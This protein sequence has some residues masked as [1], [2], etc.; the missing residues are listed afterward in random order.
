MGYKKLKIR[1]KRESSS[2]EVCDLTVKDTHNYVSKNGII[3][4]NSGII[5]N[6]S[7]T[8]ELSAAKL[9][10]KANDAAAASRKGSDQMTKTGVLVTSKPVKSRF[11][12]PIKVKFQ[13]PFFA[14]PNKY[15]G[16]ESFMTW[17]NSGVVRGSMIDQKTYD[18]LTDAAKD[19]ILK[20]E[21]NGEMKYC[22][23]KD[24][25]RG[26][27]CRHLGRQVSF[28][29]FFSD[30]VFTPEFLDYL[31]TNVIHPM[32]DLPKQDS[33]EDIKE[34]EDMVLPGE[35]ADSED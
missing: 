24:T 11:C 14:Q 4:H 35:S 12:R 32:F 25:A 20:F 15:L 26:I 21:Y 9:E 22:E 5:Y 2:R 17:E 19:K 18:K 28:Q 16:L 13:I 8:I 1:K 31:N 10:D 34:I 6:S 27:V 3:N 7:I 33:F 23:A 30:T 29:E